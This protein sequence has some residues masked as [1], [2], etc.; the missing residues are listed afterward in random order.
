MSVLAYTLQLWML[1]LHIKM[2]GIF[3][4]QVWNCMF[5]LLHFTDINISE[6]QWAYEN[7]CMIKIMK[8]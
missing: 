6:G 3:N 1:W 8:K 2:R 7:K 4:F 5:F